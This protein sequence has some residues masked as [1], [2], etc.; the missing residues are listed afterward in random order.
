MLFDH[1]VYTSQCGFL[2]RSSGSLFFSRLRT[3]SGGF[4]VS[5]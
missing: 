5:G 2:L 3:L 4:A 1:I